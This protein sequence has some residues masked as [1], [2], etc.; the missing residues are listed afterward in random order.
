MNS[1]QEIT[2]SFCSCQDI[3]DSATQSLGKALQ[4]FNGSL[5]AIKIEFQ[6]SEYITDLAAK[7]Y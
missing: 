5:K 2:L 3:T 4:R 7:K 1:L 6:N